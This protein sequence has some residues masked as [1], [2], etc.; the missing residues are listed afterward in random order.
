MSVGDIKGSRRRAK[1]LKRAG[2]FPK[3]PGMSVQAL[4][5]RNKDIASKAA[6]IKKG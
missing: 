6:K 4:I 1:L 3:A 5:Q 2:H